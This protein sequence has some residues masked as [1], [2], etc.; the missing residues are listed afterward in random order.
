MLLL[1]YSLAQ[2]DDEGGHLHN[3]V[4]DEL[5][6]WLRLCDAAQDSITHK[7]KDIEGWIPSKVLLM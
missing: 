3:G 6:Q 2:D 4:D 7:V 5:L 1:Q